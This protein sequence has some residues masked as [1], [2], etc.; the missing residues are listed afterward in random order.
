[1]TR[2]VC[3]SAVVAL[4]CIA[5]GAY[6]ADVAAGKLANTATATGVPPANGATPPD[7]ISSPPSPVTIKAV[8]VVV[9]TGG[10]PATVAGAPLPLGLV[11][12]ALLALG[13]SFLGASKLGRRY[14]RQW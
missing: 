5:T 6:A 10:T 14:M 9:Q 2:L 7:K 3:F 13:A 1:M 8:T 12:V 4:S 11:I